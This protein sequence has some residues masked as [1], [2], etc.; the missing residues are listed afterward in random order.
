M[1]LFIFT[2]KGKSYEDLFWSI[3]AKYTTTPVCEVLD[4]SF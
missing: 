4:S 1:P 3:C 2:S